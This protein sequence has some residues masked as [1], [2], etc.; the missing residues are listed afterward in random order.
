MALYDRLESENVDV[1]DRIK[2]ICQEVNLTPDKVW[3]F[4][5]CNKALLM[6]KS[7]STTKDLKDSYTDYDTIWIDKIMYE[8]DEQHLVEAEIEYQSLTEELNQLIET[9]TKREQFVIKSR[10]YDE[11]TLEQT[12]KIVGVTRERIRQIE[13]KALRK[14]RRLAFHHQLYVYR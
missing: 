4:L 7:L 12:G 10:Y 5:K 8:D 6:C 13:S 14:L 9:L 11:L 1:E 3:E 2:L